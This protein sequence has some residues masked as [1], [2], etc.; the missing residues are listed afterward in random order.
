[1]ARA[2]VALVAVQQ[3]PGGGAAAPRFIIIGTAA[4]SDPAKDGLDWRYICCGRAE[5]YPILAS[6]NPFA[7]AGGAGGYWA[8]ESVLENGTSRPRGLFSEEE[9]DALEPC[10]FGGTWLKTKLSKIG[11]WTP[12]RRQ[13]A[14]VL[15]HIERVHI[16]TAEG[17]LSRADPV[18]ALDTSRVV[19]G[20]NAVEAFDTRGADGEPVGSRLVLFPDW[21]AGSGALDAFALHTQIRLAAAGHRSTSASSSSARFDTRLMLDVGARREPTHAKRRNL[22]VQ[23]TGTPDAAR[24]FR[25]EKGT[26]SCSTSP[27]SVR[28]HGLADTDVVGLALDD[29]AARAKDVWPVQASPIAF[30]PAP[31]AELQPSWDYGPALEAVGLKPPF[32]VKRREFGFRALKVADDGSGRITRIGWRFEATIDDRSKALLKAPGAQ[33]VIPDG[34][35]DGLPDRD[36][37]LAEEQRV[38]DIVLDP[39]QQPRRTLVTF[40]LSGS[41]DINE[42]DEKITPKVLAAFNEITDRVQGGL[43]AVQDGAPLSLL[44]RFS[45]TTGAA[46]WHIVGVVTDRDRDRHRRPVQT[47]SASRPR[48]ALQVLTFEPRAIANMWAGLSAAPLTFE[49]TATFRRFV[50]TDRVAPTFRVRLGRFPYAEQALTREADGTLGPA[51][52]PAVAALPDSAPVEEARGLWLSVQPQR[53]TDRGSAEVVL[54][55]LAFELAPLADPAALRGF[56][57]LM[58][59]PGGAGGAEQLASRIRARISLPLNDVTPGGEDEPPGSTRARWEDD[60][61]AIDEDVE[62]PA[63]GPLVFPLVRRRARASGR[64]TV[65]S[66]ETATRNADHALDLKLRFVPVGGEGAAQGQGATL[67]TIGDVCDVIDE[68]PLRALVIE[69]NPFRVFAVDYNDIVSEASWQE[70]AAAV[71]TSDGEDGASWQVPDTAQTLRL[72]GP[73]QVL[74]EAMEKN[75]G[76]IDG[77]PPDIAPD[78]PAAARF[79]AL[80]VI[81]VDPT[82]QDRDFR[83]PGWNLSRILGRAQQ[84]QPGARVLNLRTELLY[85]MTT[86]VTAEGIWTTELAGAIGVQAEPGASPGVAALNAHAEQASRVLRKAARRIAVE[87]LYRNRPDEDL[88]IED[89]VS[90]KLRH[91]MDPAGAGRPRRGPA[92]PVRWPTPGGIPSDTGG[93]IDREL[94]ARTFSASPDDRDSF[95]GGV[96][97]AFESANI[98]MSVFRRPQSEGGR[99]GGLALSA[100]GGYG[101]QRALFDGRRTVVESVTS[102]GRVHRFRLERIG[103]INCLWNRAK[104]VIVYERTVVPSRQ[105]YNSAPIGLGQDEQLGRAILRKVEEY[106]EILQPMRRFPE[107]GSSVTEAGFLQG[108]EFKSTKILVDS[109]WGADVRREGWRVPLWSTEF[110]GLKP[111]PGNPDDPA[112]VYPKPQIRVW[113]AGEGGREVPYEVTEPEK[114]AFYT[115]VID[116]EDDNTDA[117]R[118][119]RDVDFCDL[120][121]PATPKVSTG[122]ADLTDDL[123]AS[124]RAHVPGYE[125]CTIGITS[126]GLPVSLAHNRV[127]G[128]PVAALQ[129]L[130]IARGAPRGGAEGAIGASIGV[131]AGL[132]AGTANLGADLDQLLSRAL[133]PLNRLPSGISDAK[134]EA[135]KRLADVAEVLSEQALQKRIGKH[136]DALPGLPANMGALCKGLV[137]NL[138]AQTSGQLN[139]LA[140]SAGDLLRHGA[141]ALEQSAV[142][143]AAPL[144]P[145]LGDLEARADALRRLAADVQASPPQSAQLR[146]ALNRELDLV[147][148]QIAALAGEARDAV[149]RR[150]GAAIAVLDDLA[151]AEP[152]LIT[153]LLEFRARARADVGAI[154]AQLVDLAKDTTERL[155]QAIDDAVDDADAAVAALVASGANVNDAARAAGVSLSARLDELAKAL[156]QAEAELARRNAPAAA[157][158]LV[159]ALWPV[160]QGAQALARRL[161]IA[162]GAVG[163]LLN[164]LRAAVSSFKA[165]AQAARTRLAAVA[166]LGELDQLA[167]LLDGVLDTAVD[168]ARKLIRDASGRIDPQLRLQLQALDAGVDATLATLQADLQGGVAA[169]RA[170]IAAADTDEI[171]QAIRDAAAALAQKLR[172]TA[173]GIGRMAGELRKA[174]AA[175][176]AALERELEAA[177]QTT[178]RRVTAV[179]DAALSR[180]KAFSGELSATCEKIEGWLRDLL[181]DP[182]NALKEQFERALDVARYGDE[183][184]T[185]LEN[186]IDSVAN[187]ATDLVEAIKRRANQAAQRVSREVDE[188]TRQLTGALQETARELTGED[189]TDLKRRADG[190]YQKGDAAIR[191]IRAIG[192]PPHRE[193][194]GFNKEVVGYVLQAK[195]LGVDMTPALALVNRT[196]DQVAAVQQAGKAVGELL[197]SFGVRLPVSR[198]TDQLVPDRLKNLS[199]AD[200]L[201]DMGGI[202]FRGLLSG[203]GFPELDDSKA[204][205][206][207]H[208]VDKATLSAWM[209]AKLDIPFIKPAT[210]F[211]F[212]PVDVVVETAQFTS[213]ARMTAGK[214]GLTK[215]MSGRIHGDWRVACGGQTILTF[216]QTALTFDADGKIDFKI[217]PEKVV[218]AEALKFITD[219]MK[220]TGQKGG[221]N[222]APFMRG[223]IPSGVAAT[224]DMVLPPIQ[225]GVFGIQDLSLH[226]LFGIAAL[227]EFE[228]VCELSVGT[229]IAPFTLNIWVLNGGGWLTQTLSYLPTRKPL[230]LLV[231]HLEI[232]IAVGLGI[233][234]SFGVV[235]GG[236]WLQVG[237]SLLV[238]WRTGSG[239]ST[240]AMRVFVLLR[241]SVDVA[242]LITAYLLL[243]FDLVYDGRN[244]IGHG[245]MHFEVRISVFYTLSVTESVQYVFAGSGGEEEGASSDA[246]C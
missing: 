52:Q 17:G 78:R 85:Q 7:L 120:P 246:Y 67:Q 45:D 175:A 202:D 25:I 111:Q 32:S 146:A 101:S 205:K 188:R 130:T 5:L 176:L 224:L 240:T 37:W 12:T 147:D 116:G 151:S 93:L 182:A 140:A 64:L 208:G 82:Y 216:R 97:W 79:G 92:T 8:P 199:V 60:P 165:L 203:V 56:V 91:R 198:L 26:L 47:G 27:A 124:E 180:V 129:N 70:S 11:P 99:V 211:S 10:G 221:L 128:G 119:V 59:L 241:G 141:L 227:P 113:L 220:A 135:K 9:L 127:A 107:D 197:D 218:L 95:A 66:T 96:G 44:P 84:R 62:P 133:Q 234:F 200:L 213:S 155:I 178:L 145:L 71:W 166:E 204:V 243:M 148:A 33:G 100:L 207:R 58:P 72:I 163:Q 115:S 214:G 109:R 76:A 222:V 31:S 4:T 152:S 161:S 21:V 192:D 231:Y 117:W 1:M 65:M 110:L 160:V 235:S 162:T 126:P 53:R 80:S 209:E 136:L 15:R 104:H 28:S 134:T 158:R 225:T 143:A 171:D 51:F 114:L 137:S 244:L 144:D 228:L 125:W 49:A 43:K 172:A 88:L 29:S 239:G 73:P 122:S 229:R 108:S 233:G 187:D 42:Y 87:K 238:D 39:D 226:V 232:G 169:L 89:G 24:S 41:D 55:A 102:Q 121:F 35:W 61:K 173:D 63:D 16:F 212:G 170:A 131:G 177:L 94:L 13:S 179:N 48:P 46:P 245:T 23:K 105:F 184:R 112:L 242:G 154:K 189:L 150:I 123:T 210:L 118:P 106:V 77:R 81:D 3:A 237:C 219:L 138:E 20:A 157:R 132:A 153:E 206:V 83:E 236:V 68:G 74:A 2:R 103:R 174:T 75:R 22:W 194:I 86:R 168:E 195:E 54:G 50:T 215:E 6:E 18:A 201:P 167:A 217:Q 19:S 196:A 230:P 14:L 191:A 193:G 159:Q 139:R 38:G 181:E 183:L 190:I 30:G 164:Q 142:A 149:H 69:P 156:A 90:F 185:T 186:E 36:V 57:R 223:G 98:L 34:L 40:R